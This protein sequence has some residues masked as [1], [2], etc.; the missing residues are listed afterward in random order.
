MPVSGWKIHL[1]T[2]HITS[3][4]FSFSLSVNFKNPCDYLDTVC[5]NKELGIV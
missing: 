5:E 4:K 3:D 2:S 1:G